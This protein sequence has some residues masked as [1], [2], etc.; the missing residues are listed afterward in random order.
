MLATDLEFARRHGDL[1][2]SV[3]KALQTPVHLVRG[4]AAPDF[5]AHSFPRERA[6]QTVGRIRRERS[7]YRAIGRFHPVTRTRHGGG[8]GLILARVLE[9]LNGLLPG[10]RPGR[11][12]VRSR[13]KEQ[14]Q[15]KD[16]G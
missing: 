11:Q 5:Q 12:V 13:A 7:G 16:D 3:A 9:M 2:R 1:R 4:F 14:Q 6:A 8:E 10:E 15:R